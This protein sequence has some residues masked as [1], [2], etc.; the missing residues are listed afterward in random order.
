L[1]Q[2]STIAKHHRRFASG[3]LYLTPTGAS[4]GAPV[5]SGAQLEF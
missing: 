2:A 1:A 3:N 4:R 5:K